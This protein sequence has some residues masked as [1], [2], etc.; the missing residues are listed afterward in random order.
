MKY[1]SVWYMMND[2]MNLLKSQCYENDDYMKGSYTHTL[3][4]TN[5][6]NEC[7][8]ESLRLNT[9]RELRWRV[10]GNLTVSKSFLR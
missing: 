3:E 2:V 8:K 5:E 4:W 7:E 10:S 6:V 9:L 1:A